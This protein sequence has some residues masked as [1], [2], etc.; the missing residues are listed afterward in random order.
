MNPRQ[1]RSKLRSPHFQRA[2]LII[3]L[4]TFMA[5]VFSVWSVSIS[6]KAGRLST[7][8]SY[9]DVVYL[10][11]ASQYYFDAKRVSLSN[12]VLDFF[13]EYTHSPAI[14]GLAIAGFGIFGFDY[15]E[16][17]YA[18]ALVVCAYLAFVAL[19][20]RRLPTTPLVAVLSASLA[21][22]FATLAA[23]E[24]RPDLLWATFLTG[25]CVWFLTDPRVFAS[26][27]PSVVFGLMMGMAFLA[28]PSTFAMTFVVCGGSWFL[29]ACI[30]VYARKEKFR[31]ISIGLA[32]TI[33]SVV[34][35]AGW[36]C[37]PHGEAIYDYF[38]VHSFGEHKDVWVFE[39]SLTERMLHYLKGIPAHSNLG[40]A[41]IPL[42]VLYIGGVFRDIARP[43]AFEDR[44]RGIAFLWMLVC[45][46]LVNS[47]FTL[48]S[49]YLGG[50]FYGFLIFGGIWNLS[51]LLNWYFTV[52]SDREPV[53]G[54][55][56]RSLAIVVVLLF[57]A[58]SYRF[59]ELCKVPRSSAKERKVIN[60]T[61]VSDI[62]PKD[63]SEKVKLILTQGSPVISEYIQMEF[64]KRKKQAVVENLF[65]NREFEV[66]EDAVK[67]ADYVVVQDPGLP[68]APGN[69][70]PAEELLP[71]YLEYLQNAPEWQLMKEY[72]VEG[73]KKIYLFSP[74]SG[75]IEADL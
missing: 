28:K 62:M 50:A 34:V 24:F 68:D 55:K 37:I 39:G 53:L 63:E 22:P 65:V 19:I 51:R 10:N 35:S 36:Y 31:A 47:L 49:P 13:T 56:L 40:A 8:S 70:M 44:L 69:S 41:Y 57:P 38:H 66:F 45:L 12:E 17:Y 3:L 48:K 42:F 33:V 18:L 72:P 67:T 23:V 16:V 73:G 32:L 52:N 6:R 7:V 25:G 71:R 46:Y 11:R 27:L 29:A 58:S 15:V 21:I 59:P 54:R 30:G 26:R 5:G 1:F 61:L 4:I 2:A 74:K 9:D 20:C 43:A 60:R 64:R 14:V 75:Q